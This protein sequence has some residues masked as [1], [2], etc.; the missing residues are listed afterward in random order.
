MGEWENVSMG[1][2]MSNLGSNK[3]TVFRLNTI[4]GSNI[5]TTVESLSDQ[6]L[7]GFDDRIVFRPRAAI[8]NACCTT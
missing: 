2:L 8:F 1:G 6:C 5:T 7:N 4:D 3:V